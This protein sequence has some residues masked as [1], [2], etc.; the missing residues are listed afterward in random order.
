VYVNV[1][2]CRHICRKFRIL[3]LTSLY[4]LDALCFIKK[5][6]G[7]LNKILEYMVIILNNNSKFYLHTCYCN[8]VLYQRSVTNMVIKLFNNL[9]VQIK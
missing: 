7:N 3:T 8:T 9:P 4:I 6:Q 1:N 5:Y 2:F